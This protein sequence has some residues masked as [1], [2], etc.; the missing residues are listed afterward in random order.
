MGGSRRG[1]HRRRARAGAYP[2]VCGGTFLWVKAL[3]FG[4]APMPG[5]SEAVRA[6]H[7]AVAESSG[8]PALHASL[9]AVDPE[10]AERLHPNDFVRVSRAL[11]VL[12]LTGRP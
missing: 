4:L 10:I 1:R 9:R 3:L 2:I 7:R 11:E 8:R 12:E 6:R 5:A